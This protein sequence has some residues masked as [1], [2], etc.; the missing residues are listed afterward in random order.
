MCLSVVF[1][2]EKIIESGVGYKVFRKYKQEPY[3]RDIIPMYFH[4][5]IHKPIKLK[6]WINEIEYRVGGHIGRKKKI[7]RDVS[8][9]YPYGFHI[10]L[11]KYGAYQLKNGEPGRIVKKIKFRKGC[12]IGTQS[13][14]CVVVVAKEIFV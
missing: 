9:P 13:G 8:K 3:P 1:P 10:F 12:A 4:R 2:K 14:H 11:N 5:Y 7:I 6:K